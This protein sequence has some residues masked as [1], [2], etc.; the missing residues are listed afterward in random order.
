MKVT[1]TEDEHCWLADYD[2]SFCRVRYNLKSVLSSI[3]LKTD[4]DQLQSADYYIWPAEAD[5]PFLIVVGRVWGLCIGS[6]EMKS[7]MMPI[8]E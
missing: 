8:K 4:N 6:S 2:I 3:Q 7:N 1:P 5:P